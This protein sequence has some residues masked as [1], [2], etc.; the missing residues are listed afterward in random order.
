MRT[1]A[2]ILEGERKSNAAAVGSDDRCNRG[3]ALWLPIDD[4]AAGYS[5]IQSGADSSARSQA[6]SQYCEER[7]HGIVSLVLQQRRNRGAE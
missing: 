4:G 2:R 1:S 3:S 7:A 5:R 6:Q